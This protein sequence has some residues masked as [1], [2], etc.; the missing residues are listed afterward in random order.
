MSSMSA[1]NWGVLTLWKTSCKKN[2]PREMN[3]Y[4]PVALMS[5][6]MKTLKQLFLNILR[7]QVQYAQDPLQFAYRAAVGVKD[8]VLHL[9]HWAHTHLD[10]G[11]GSVRILFLDFSSAFNTIKPSL[12][13]EKL[14]VTVLL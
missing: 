8:A 10:E 13:Q 11:S 12:L 14:T 5:H 2:R 1:H 9:L 7:P 3:D 4:R 6:L